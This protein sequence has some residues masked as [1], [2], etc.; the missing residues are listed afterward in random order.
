M[1]QAADGSVAAAGLVRVAALEALVW[2]WGDAYDIGL[3]DGTW[4]FQRRDGYGGR[5]TAA[6]SEALRGAI[7]QNYMHRPV[8]REIAT[9]VQERRDRY[10]VAGVRIWHDPGGWHARWAVDHAYTGITR[11]DLIALLDRLDKL[12]ENAAKWLAERTD[13]P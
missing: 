3:C 1:G 7:I 11:P 9:Q 2:H 10:E 12:K 13:K 4:W 5:E 8:R 6:S